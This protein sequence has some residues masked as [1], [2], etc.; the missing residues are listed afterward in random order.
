MNVRDFLDVKVLCE[1][2]SMR[3]A[4]Q[5]IGIS[6]PTLSNRIAHLE[7]KLGVKLFDRNHR[8][9]NPTALARFIASRADVISSEAEA[10][11]REVRRVSQGREGC[12]TLGLGPG[13]MRALLP[14]IVAAVAR[15]SKMLSLKVVS[16]DN[17]RLG[18]WLRS[19]Q[20][21]I[22]VCPPIDGDD[23]EIV[24]ELTADVHSV[25][26]AKPDHPV[27]NGGAKDFASLLDQRVAVPQFEPA[28]RDYI[29]K[30]YGV[31][32]DAR[33]GWIYCSDYDQIVRMMTNGMPLLSGGPA[34]VF[35]REIENG[36]LRVVDTPVPFRTAFAVQTNRTAY[37]FPAVLGLLE[38]V[39]ETFS[40][41]MAADRRAHGSAA[42]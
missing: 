37:P 25:I 33:P 17:A 16:G 13:P 4:A 42:S 15:R 5:Q 27:F 30:N 31:D 18:E 36:V 14:A 38:I 9:S 34:I 7:E 8:R 41:V 3:K 28:E 1:A 12:V 19:R 21:D 10:L 40:E 6:Q 29:Q 22:A 39:V 2:G 11:S 32:V 20:I 23:A 24:R 35:R 26:V